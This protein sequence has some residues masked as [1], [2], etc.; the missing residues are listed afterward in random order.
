MNVHAQPK[1][2]ANAPLHMLPERL[3]HYAFVVKDQEANRK[4]WEDVIGIHSARDLVRARL[5]WVGQ[6]RDRLLPYVL[7]AG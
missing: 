6:P 1:A 2:D 5:Q 4:F 3:H 7:C